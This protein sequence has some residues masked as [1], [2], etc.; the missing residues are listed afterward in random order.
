MI[1]VPSHS[2]EVV[3][4]Q[5]K[6]QTREKWEENDSDILIPR[7]EIVPPQQGASLAYNLKLWRTR[8]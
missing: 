1:T 2:N 7:N 4:Y 8:Q 3:G 5:G 6:L